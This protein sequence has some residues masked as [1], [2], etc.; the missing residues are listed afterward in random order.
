MKSSGATSRVGYLKI[1]DVSWT[2]S[3]PITSPHHQTLLTGT[4]MAPETSVIFK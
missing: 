4:E 1:T 3:V 2:I